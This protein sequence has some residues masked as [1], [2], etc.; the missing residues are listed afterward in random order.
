M[1]SKHCLNETP[2]RE[3]FP[4]FH[5]KMFHTESMTLAYWHIDADSKIH[6]HSHPHEQVVNMIS[7]TFYLEL[8]GKPFTLTSGDVLIIPRNLPHQGHAVTDCQ[9]LDI[10]QPVREDYR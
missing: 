3:F 8:D 9:I 7:G 2:S 5:G 4:G 10:F 6:L 1:I